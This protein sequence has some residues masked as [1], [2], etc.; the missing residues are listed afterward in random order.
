M[1]AQPAGPGPA[2]VAAVE[3]VNSELYEAFEA[4]DLDRMAAVWDDERPGEVVCIHP[5]WDAVRGRDRVL[6][7]WAAIMANTAFVQF[8]LTDVQ[9]SVLAD[10]AVVTCVENIVTT[11]EELDS[12]ARIVT[13]NLF[14]RGVSG[15]RLRLHHGSP[16]LGGKG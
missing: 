2:E 15:W 12:N 9:T 3:A 10:I 8:V 11:M 5:G 16:V 7:S 14:H 13:T 6:R 4:G 1:T